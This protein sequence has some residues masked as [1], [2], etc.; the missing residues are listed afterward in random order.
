MADVFLS[1]R[2]DDS[3]SATGRLAD[4]LIGLARV[5]QSAASI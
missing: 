2:R 3:R 5:A 1:Y 4:G